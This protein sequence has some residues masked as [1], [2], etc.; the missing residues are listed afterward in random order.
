VSEPALE[1]SSLHKTFDPGLLKRP[2]EALRGI[3][4]EVPRG[5]IYGFLGPNGAGKTTTLNAILGLVRPDSGHIRI[6]GIEHVRPEARRRLGFAPENPRLY[7]HLTGLEYLRFCGQL[8]EMPVAQLQ[9]RVDEVLDMVSMSG[10]ADRPMRTFSKG[11]QQRLSL[12]QAL[13]GRPELLLLD[14]PMSGLDPLGRRDVRDL[15][16]AERERGTTVFFSSHVIP[17]VEAL[18]DRV[19]LVVEGRVRAVGSVRELL[20]R[21]VE[22][23]EA[24]F[25]GVSP[26]RLR[27]PVMA[28]HEGSDASWV[29]IG[30]G[31]RDDLLGELHD[32]G[33]RVMSLNPVRST[34]E[35]FLVRHVEGGS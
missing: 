4:L 32:A 18:C 19:A 16:L 35:T 24:T 10:R 9:R 17:D 34:L 3:D 2:V 13:L 6:S 21:E 11:M 7:P 29:R 33:A 27:T 20:A 23:Y 15:I 30:A 5:E 8:L 25:V 31:N 1:V 12:A 22:A 26:D 14:E 28:S